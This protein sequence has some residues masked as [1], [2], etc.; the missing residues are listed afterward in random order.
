[1]RVVVAPDG[2]TGSLTAAQAVASITAGW[3][4]VAPTDELIGLPL[5]DGGPGF[6]DAIRRARPTAADLQ[7]AATGPH[8]EPVHVPV[9]LVPGEPAAAAGERPGPTAYIESAMV[10]GRAATAVLDDTAHATSFGLA[11]PIRAALAA[12][13][14]R[15]VVGLGGSLTTD[16]GAGLLAGLGARARGTYGEWTD[17]PLRAGGIGLGGIVGID[18]APVRDLL[19]G[20]DLVVAAD[21]DNPLTGPRGAARGFGPQKGADPAAVEALD[22]A[23]SSFAAVLGR[24]PDGRSAA[25][26]LGSGAAGGV[27]FALLHVGGRYVSGAGLVL[28]ELRVPDSIAAADLVVTGEGSFDWQSLRGKVVTGVCQ[29]AMD[30]GRPV[31]VLA[32][33]LGVGRREWMAVGVSAAYSILDP[34]D[35]APDR[36]ALA[37]AMADAPELLAAVAARAARTWSR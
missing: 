15:I 7:V 18:V 35:P 26:A 16:A 1:M 10:L 6:L 24:R 34:A 32:G 17:A 5:S 25:V 19:A 37:A 36:A 14:S 21:V 33:R 22:S 23:L 8:D 29:A 27:G 28:A 20:V 12:G 9:L 3:H 2:F 30:S 13:A 11:A 4:S 31:V